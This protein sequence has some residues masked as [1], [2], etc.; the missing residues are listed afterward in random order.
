MIQ[1]R[2][3]PRFPLE[4]GEPFRIAR[5]LRRQ[6]LDSDVAPQ[7][8]VM[9]QIHFPHAAS[10]DQGAD[11]IGAEHVARTPDHACGKIPL[12]RR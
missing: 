4:T 6:G 12:I 9:R 2:K 7:F 5:A 10:S 11:F 3:H 8:P 1:S